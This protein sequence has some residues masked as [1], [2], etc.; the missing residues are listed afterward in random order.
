M[1]VPRLLA[2]AILAATAL[3]AHAAIP[4][5]TVGGS[6]ITFEGL[7]QYDG[8]WFNDDFRDLDGDPGDSD[9]EDAFRRTE[10][11]L[12]GAGPGPL[13]WVLGYDVH[14]RR[15]LDVN[16]AWKLAGGST[17]VMGQAKV[18]FG[19]D[20]LGSSRTMDFMSKAAAVV[21]FAPSRRVGVQ[22]QMGGAHWYAAA[23]LFGR[24][25]AA[26]TARGDGGAARFAWAPVQAEGRL[27]HLGLAFVDME[28][29]LDTVR[30]R[31][32]PQADLS[33]LRVI[34]TGPLLEADHQRSWGLEG[35]W[36]HDRF[37]VQAE[38]LQSD[39]D[40]DFG[41]GD[42]SADGGYVSAVWNISGETWAYKNGVVT[43]AAPANP[44][45]LWQLGLRYDTLDL[46]DHG[47]AGGTMHALTT[48]VNWYWRA[49]TRLSV[50]YVAV[51][52]E[53]NGV[54]D[55]PAILEARVQFHW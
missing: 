37:K 6:A 8:N 53:R 25:M 47:T 33:A 5:G 16:L 29:D 54:D 22:W 11:V 23:G 39:I 1:T 34:D 26:E 27:L 12:K 17:L 49:N 14:A 52:S 42:F 44:G 9:S 19:L 2:L 50:N 32:R 4:V 7:V 3:P 55:D 21:A 10:L 36:V 41:S 13:A 43:T 15:W 24:E 18:P 38:W 35:A 51:N 31:A 40:R 20:E 28:P 45:G 30:L 48:G 46:D